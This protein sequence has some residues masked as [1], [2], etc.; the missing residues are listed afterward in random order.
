[1]GE[2]LHIAGYS[3]IGLTLPAGLLDNRVSS[4]RRVFEEKGLEAL[5]RVDLV[6]RSRDELLRLL[7]RYRNRL[8]LIAVKC[9]NSNVA[10]VASRD[11]RVDIIF[12]DTSSRS[13][14]FSHTHASL[15]RGALEL[16][17]V[18]S[19]HGA[20]TET[21]TRIAREASIAT[22]HNTR[23]ILS[24]G[25]T[26]PREVRSPL[27][28]SALGKAIGLSNNQALTGVAEVPTAI[29]HRNLE[30]RSGRYIEEGVRVISAKAP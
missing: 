6:P 9:V 30:R 26:T 18:A 10:A 11:R 16:N 4:L 17:L 19:L 25:A 22:S 27:Q 29:A 24:S 15:L 1:M 3:L 14:R 28:L 13:T 12:F 5:L 8:D 23:V 7:R 2:L 21:Y 20:V